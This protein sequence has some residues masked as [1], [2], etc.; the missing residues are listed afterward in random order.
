MSIYLGIDFGTSTNY[1]TRW[2]EEDGTI[3]AV[4]NMDPS[5]YTGD[6]VFPNVIYYQNN[7][8]NIVG[9]SAIKFS[10][11]DPRNGVNGVKRKLV[12]NNWEYI[13]PALSM[14]YTPVEVATDIFKYIKK[15]VSENNGGADIAGVVISVPYA[16]GNKERLKIQKS[17]ERAGL[18]VI[19]LIEEPV[20]AAISYGIFQKNS[21]MGHS[22]KIM[23]FDFGGGTL[24]ITVF[25]YSKTSDGKV[26]IEVLNTEG[27]K[28]FGGQVIDEILLAKIT[29]KA[30]I[31]ISEIKDIE[32]RLKFQNEMLLK[33]VELKEEYQYWEEDEEYDID[34]IINGIKV[35][36]SI[37]AEELENWIRGAGILEK[38]RFAV[39]D[40]L[41]DSGEKGLE[42][43]DID[44]VLLVG[45]SSNLKIVKKE[46]ENFFGKEPEVCE[47]VDINKMVGYG[48]G[49]Y[50]G[51][52]IKNENKIS[53]K[54]KLSYSIGV[55][56]GAKFDKLIAKNEPYG[57]YSKPRKYFLLESKDNRD[58]EV[59]QGNSTDI[60][61]C[62]L[63]GKIPISDLPIGESQNIEIELGTNT[64]GMVTYKVYNS[65]GN[66]IEGKIE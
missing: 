55:R 9:K 6:E 50:C 1:I 34:E 27:I 32:Q 4:P 43:E 23:V 54:Q 58:I 24:D 17:A 66:Y 44:R 11:I 65:D 10:S 38:I 53:I 46:L 25:S 47:N 51:M 49:V 3:K 52:K 15:R 39:D 12:E 45:G 59:Y 57:T 63:I 36:V 37:S 18:N 62:F 16:Y 31:N 13:I 14:K 61:K 42:K 5:I 64:A 28:N 26:S 33:I 41:I 60:K 21:T 35:S 48:A 29:E 7:G 20:A 8:K 22:E 2:N 30:G 40:A 56:V 19:D